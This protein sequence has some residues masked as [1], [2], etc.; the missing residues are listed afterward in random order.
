MKNQTNK[1]VPFNRDVSQE[2]EL[3]KALR[4]VWLGR[5]YEFQT[6]KEFDDLPLKA[7]EAY[8]I[9]LLLNDSDEDLPSNDK[10]K[11]LVGK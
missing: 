9:R 4:S 8:K 10:S 3:K 5:R 7:E 6:F 2:I 11:D 1:K